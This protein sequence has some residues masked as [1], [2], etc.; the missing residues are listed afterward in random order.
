MQKTVLVADDDE[1]M[2]DLVGM[3]ITNLGHRVASARSA[4]KALELAELHR[5]ALVILDFHLPDMNGAA[6]CQSLRLNPSTRKTPVIFMTADEKYAVERICFSSKGDDFMLKPIDP[7]RFQLHLGR[8]LEQLDEESGTQEPMELHGIRLDPLGKE[9]WIG[10]RQI[11]LTPILFK[12]LMCF[13]R[14]PGRLFS[15]EELL[16]KMWLP[17]SENIDVRVVDKA[18]ERLRGVLGPRLKHVVVTEYG[19]GFKMLAPA[20]SRPSRLVPLPTVIKDL[21][22][23]R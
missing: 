21:D 14:H 20:T 5:P 7:I 10:A 9:A 13:M 22:V 18:I 19:Q 17:S 1:G 4:K 6:L 16:Q 23:T 11:H 2:L 15:K 8:R 12:L 3:I